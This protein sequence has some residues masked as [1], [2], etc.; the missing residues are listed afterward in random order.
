MVLPDVLEP[1]LKVVFCGTAVGDQSARR[2]AYYAGPGNQFWDILAD[3]G[4]TPL[5]LRPEQYPMLTNYGIGLTDLVKERSGRDT[6][7]SAHDFVVALFKSKIE[8]FSPKAVGFNGKKAAEEFFGCKGIG[9]GRQKECIGGT[10]IFVLPSTSGAARGFWDPKYWHEVAGVVGDSKM[11]TTK[12]SH[13]GD[14]GAAPRSSQVKVV[15]K[16]RVLRPS[17]RKS[18][19]QYRVKAEDVGTGDIL[20]LTISHESSPK[21]P[22]AIYEFLGS[23]IGDRKS[24]YFTA[25]DSGDSW[26]LKFVGAIPSKTRYC[27]D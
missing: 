2:G 27:K 17:S 12:L 6:V 25:N 4:L 22:I 15:A 8:R 5:R 18:D 10:A 1:G 3:T 23:D 26:K 13:L 14:E 9:Y 16:M 20:R 19:S 24:I 11:A 7:L 21:K